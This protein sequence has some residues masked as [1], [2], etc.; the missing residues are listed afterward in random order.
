MENEIKIRNIMK[1][2]EPLSVTSKLEVIDR[3]TKDVS[4]DVHNEQKDKTLLLNEL[5]GSWKDIGDGFIED[6]M[7]SRTLSERDINFR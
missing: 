7:N 3:L 5:Y 1:L 6:V 2:L 4:T